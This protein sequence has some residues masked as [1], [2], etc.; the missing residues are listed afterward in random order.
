M[1][2]THILPCALPRAEADA[3]NRESGR[4]YTQVLVTHWRIVRKHRAWLGCYTAKKLNDWFR[5]DESPLLHAHSVDAAQEAFH[6]A[7]KTANACKRAGLDKTR[8]PYKRKYF[9]ATIWKSS[10]IRR[11][12]DTLLLSL[13]RGLQPIVV[14]LPAHLRSVSDAREARLVYDLKARRYTWHLFQR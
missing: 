14:M 1:I 7:C 5:T 12:G 2:R 8:Y 9:R 11:Q 13:A 4:I 10:A 3:L 6:K